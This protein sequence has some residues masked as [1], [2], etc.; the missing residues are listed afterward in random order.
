MQAKAFIQKLKSAELTG[1]GCG[2]FPT[3]VKWDAV[4]NSPQKE[5][6][7]VCNAAESEPGIFKDK[8]ILE[9]H[10]QRVLDGIN[11]ALKLLKAR[12]GFIYLNPH[13]Y[14]KLK[15]KLQ[16][17][18]GGDKIEIFSKPSK[19]YLGGE[20]TAMLNNM[21]G[22]R[23]EARLRPPFVVEKGLFGKP[24][25][26]NNA[27]TFHDIALIDAGQYDHERFFCVSGTGAAEGVY[28]F[29]ENYNVRRALEASGQY[30]TFKFFIQLGGAMS[31]IC[32]RENQL[33][34]Y[35]IKHYSGLVIHHLNKSEQALVSAWLDFFAE[36]SCGKCVPCREGTYRLRE[37]Y[38]T[39]GIRDPLFN[40]IIFSMNNSTICSFGKMAVTALT[41]YYENILKKPLEKI[42]KVKKCQCR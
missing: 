4:L 25:L 32:L 16:L 34:D 33:E 7:V 42:E 1:R 13:Y 20:E 27:E 2:T 23:E 14:A 30:P 11:L 22:Q 18:I 29:P 19:G 6:Y 24:T 17:L 39:G 5:R 12:Q 37:L 21:E 38:R 8:F 3:W 28:R 41:S 10:P 26:V 40:D 35:K 9:N 31:G 36:N 15:N